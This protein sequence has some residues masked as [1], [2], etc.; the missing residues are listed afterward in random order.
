MAVLPRAGVAQGG[1]VPMDL[2]VG[3]AWLRQHGIPQSAVGS[4]GGTIVGQSDRA[5]WSAAVLGACGAHGQCTGQGVANAAVYAAPGQRARWELGLT[6]SDIALD[7]AT[8]TTSAQLTAREYVGGPWRA[9]Y[10]GVGAG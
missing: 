10:A 5:G 3:G 6:T 7:G 9:A 8:P 4:Y 2:N 1:G